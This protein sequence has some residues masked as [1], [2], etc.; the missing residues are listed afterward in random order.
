MTRWPLRIAT[1]HSMARYKLPAVIT[2]FSRRYP[3]VSIQLHQGAPA[4]LA[5]MVQNG[6]AEMAIATESMHLIVSSTAHIC[7]RRHAH[8]RDYM[9]TTS[10][11][12]MPPT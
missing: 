5:Q 3:E 6:D 8:L 2:A 1:T 4:Q 7:L 11:T 12:S 9:C 10:S